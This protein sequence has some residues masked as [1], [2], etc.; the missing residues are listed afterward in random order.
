MRFLKGLV[1]LTAM[2][3][4]PATSMAIVPDPGL[5][6]TPDCIRVNPDGSVGVDVSVV[7]T[8][9]SPLGNEEVRLI[10]SASCTDLAECSG[11]SPIV[12]AL[13]SGAAGTV[14]FAPEMGG[15]C[16]ASGAAEI[17]ADPG[18]VTLASYG[19]VGSAD[20]DGSLDVALDDFVRFQAAFLTTDSC[21][22]LANCDNNVQLPDFVNFQ[23]RFLTA[24]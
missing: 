5:S 7:G 21:H 9:G 8:D 23:A 12:L 4:I 2:I 10:F 19:D 11:M 16:M 18:A 3:A 14:S 15:C 6:S 24:C 1:A 22:D 13:T 20:N 17:E